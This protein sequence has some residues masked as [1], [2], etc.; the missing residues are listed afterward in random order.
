MDSRFRG[1]DEQEQGLFRAKPDLSQPDRRHRLALTLRQ[2][3]DVEIAH[4]VVEHLAST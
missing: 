4:H 2:D 1:N 3:G